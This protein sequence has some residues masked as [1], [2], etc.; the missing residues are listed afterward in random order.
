M[1]KISFVLCLV[2]LAL[3]ISFVG[4][5]TNT[6][7][8]TEYEIE[9][10]LSNDFVLTGKEV[11]TFYNDTDNAFDHLKFNLFFHNKVPPKEIAHKT[12]LRSDLFATT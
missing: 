12:R 10:S 6:A 11:V 1:R 5:K 7:K 8:R 9:V 2:V 3:S 4:C